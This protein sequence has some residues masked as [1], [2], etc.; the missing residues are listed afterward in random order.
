MHISTPL[1]R[2]K[3]FLHHHK[4]SVCSCPHKSY[5]D[6][7]RQSTVFEPLPHKHVPLSG[8]IVFE[9]QAVDGVGEGELEGDE[10]DCLGR[11]RDVVL[12]DD[13]NTIRGLR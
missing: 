1:C 9:A 7:W 10:I 13:I 11:H 4:R 5:S 2:H 3:R 6:C 12:S 8:E